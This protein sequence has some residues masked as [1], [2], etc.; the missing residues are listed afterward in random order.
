M[1]QEIEKSSSRE[2]IEEELQEYLFRLSL[3]WNHFGG[4]F[5]EKNEGERAKNLELQIPDKIYL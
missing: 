3:L 4:C 2:E 1:A 5:G